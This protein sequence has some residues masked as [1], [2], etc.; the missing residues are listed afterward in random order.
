MAIEFE[1]KA[2]KVIVDSKDVTKV[3]VQEQVNKVDVS[4]SGPQGIPGPT[5]PTGAT[6]STGPTGATGSTGSTGPAGPTGPQGPA[7]ATQVVAYTHTQNAVS[8]SWV[9]THNLGFYP[10]VV[11]T[12][13]AGTVVEGDISFQ[14][15]N[16]LT[17]TLTHAISGYAYLS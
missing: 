15:V 6:G 7:G 14:S 8:L 11:V 12:D 1:D 10:N 9:I 16:Q 4:F 5:G 2:N 3:I 13:S 17:V